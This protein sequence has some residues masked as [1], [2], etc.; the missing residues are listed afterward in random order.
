M[1]AQERRAGGTY[2]KSAC[3]DA[4]DGHTLQVG[5]GLQN[6]LHL[7]NFVRLDMRAQG[8]AKRLCLGHHVAAILPHSVLP[9]DEGGCVKAVKS[10]EL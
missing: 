8:H 9:H 2:G 4:R 7:W 3:D 1:H 10:R 6:R 5:F